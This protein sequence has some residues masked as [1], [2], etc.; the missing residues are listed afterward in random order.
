MTA[1][2]TWLR[3]PSAVTRSRCSSCGLRLH[4]ELAARG[5]HEHVLCSVLPA[6]R[7]DALLQ[8]P[9]LRLIAGGAQ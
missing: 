5:I 6:S 4:R 7:Y 9:P 8:A 2:G 1:T 3:R